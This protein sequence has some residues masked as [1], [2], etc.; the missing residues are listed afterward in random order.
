MKK[1]ILY[2]DLIRIFACFM[3]I[4]MHAPIPN[5][6]LDNYVLSV[7]SYLTAPGIGL[8]I[9]VSGALLLTVNR[10]TFFFLRKRLKKI[11]IPTLFWT[12][13]YMM[14]LGFSRGW[15]LIELR[16][17]LSVPFSYQFCDAL[18]FVYMLT[19]LYFFAP[20]LSPWLKQI[21]RREFKFYLVIWA[22][23]MCFPFIRNYID[24]D[25]DYRGMFYYFSGYIG[26]FLLGYYLRLYLSVA[27]IWK[28]LLLLLVP[29]FFATAMKIMEIEVSFYEMFWYLSIPVVMM[30]VAWFLLIKRLD[31]TYN[32][33]SKLHRFIALVSNCCFGIYLIHIFI[34]RSI[35]WHWTWLYSLGIM[36]IVIVTFL[37]F[38]GGLALTWLI[39]YL[40]RAEYIIGFRQK[41]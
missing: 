3:I 16:R 31:M 6:G 21:G 37:T 41:R 27:S 5:T 8:F 30:C 14:L 17:V 4:A 11:I 28:V 10:P 34:M 20:I 9:M 29:L 25:E 18:W 2:L 26:Y 1:R 13:F 33:T 23:T 39:S 38:I 19:G 35:I 40:P 36:Q 22:I 32:E 24:T 15:E 12:F 7:D